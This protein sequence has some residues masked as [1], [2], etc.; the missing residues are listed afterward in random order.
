MLTRNLRSFSELPDI[1]RRTFAGTRHLFRSDIP[2][3]LGVLKLHQN[4]ALR[5]KADSSGSHHRQ[6]FQGIAAT[7]HVRGFIVVATPEY[8]DR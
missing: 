4:V 8:R 3:L 2:C 6:H 7:G 1:H 5:N